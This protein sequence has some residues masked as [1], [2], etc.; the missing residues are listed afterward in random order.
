MQEVWKFT[1]KYMEYVMALAQHQ[2][3]SAAAEAV[4]I[5]QPAM[6]HFIRSLEDKMGCKLFNRIGNRYIP[7]YEGE[8]YLYYARRILTEEAQMYNEFADIKKQGKGQI[9]FALPTLRS[10]YLLPQLVYAYRSEHPNVELKVLEAHS[11]ELERALLNGEVDFAIM[12]A[13]A[14]SPDIVCDFICHDEVLLAVPDHHP[15]AQAGMWQEGKK[16]KQ[17][18]ISLFQEDVFILQR[19]EQR[20]RKTSDYILK[21]AGITPN[22]LLETRS[23]EAALGLVSRGVGVCFIPET[24]VQETHFSG[25][26]V[27]F[28]LGAP[29]AIYN[30]SLTYLKRSYCPQYF[31]DFIR[32]VKDTILQKYN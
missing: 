30:L 12:N 23:L 29:E 21:K 5:S 13:E 26:L 25:N 9:R 18:D 11:Q 1:N 3:I 15:M 22:V 10:A 19:P 28:S 6:S 24:Y 14:K 4:F 16:Y 17:I 2:T 8:R 31:K 20:T 32:I 27:C 7:T